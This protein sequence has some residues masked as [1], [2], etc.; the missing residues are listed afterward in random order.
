MGILLIIPEEIHPQRPACWDLG[1]KPSKTP[2][3]FQK[4]LLLIPK[5]LPGHFVPAAQGVPIFP[6][7]PKNSIW[8]LGMLRSHNSRSPFPCL[9]QEREAAIPWSSGGFWDEFQA[10]VVIFSIPTWRRHL[11]LHGKDGK[12]MEKEVWKPLTALEN[13]G[14][15][16]NPT[17]MSFSSIK[18]PSGIPPTPPRV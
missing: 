12:S 13:A 10:P 15:K 6:S 16:S 2:L 7:F 5:F 17:W 3:S 18:N 8:M 11:Q 1:F 14:A 4:F 9:F